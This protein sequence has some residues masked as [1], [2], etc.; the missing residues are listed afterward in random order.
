MGSAPSRRLGSTLECISL[1]NGA[2]HATLWANIVV[3]NCCL[4]PISAFAR[5]QCNELYTLFIHIFLITALVFKPIRCCRVPLRLAGWRL[6][7]ELFVHCE[8]SRR[9]VAA[10]SGAHRGL[11]SGQ[12]PTH[13]AAS[14]FGCET[15][16][17]RRSASQRRH[18]LRYV[19]GTQ[20]KINNVLMS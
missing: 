15:R 5:Q 1:F 12:Q 6:E 18:C 16:G 14:A 17:F 19:R 9:R 13:D 3:M 11:R 2:F 10:A 8:A 4:L 20:Q 7:S